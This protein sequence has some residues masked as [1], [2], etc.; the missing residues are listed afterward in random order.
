MGNAMNNVNL[1]AFA[2]RTR[3]AL[4]RIGAPA[5]IAIALCVAGAAAWAWLL[6]QR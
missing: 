5:C 4:T 3:L 6:P 2:L 1:A